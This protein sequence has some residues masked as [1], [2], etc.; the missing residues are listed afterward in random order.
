MHPYRSWFLTLTIDQEHID[1]ELDED[2]APIGTLRKKAF[3]K[4][5]N[6]T[7]Q[8]VG[9]FRYYAV[10]EYGDLTGRPHYHLAVFPSAHCSIA[11]LKDAWTQGWVSIAELNAT[12]ARYLANYTA[13]KLTKSTDHRLSGNQEPEFRASSRRPALGAEFVRAYYRSLVKTGNIDR[14]VK[15][16]GDVPR[17]VKFDGR[18]YPLGPWALD[19]LRRLTGVPLLHTGS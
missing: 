7:A 11:D 5:I 12:R 14:L 2:A 15:A 13:K 8:R 4:W 9:S 10:G 18:T 6:N 19:K 17:T 1:H 3:L 16:Q